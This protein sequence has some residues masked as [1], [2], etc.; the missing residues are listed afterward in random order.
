MVRHPSL[1]ERLGR[2]L[3]PLDA[4]SPLARLRAEEPG[5]RAL[6]AEM[7][8]AAE[9][10]LHVARGVLL[11]TLLAV[12][13]LE[14]RDAPPPFVGIAVGAF[15]VVPVFWLVVWRALTRPRPLRWLPYVLVFV[16][17]WLA[18]RGAVAVKTP[19]YHALRADEY[20]S[21]ADLAAL[22][23]PILA[24]VAMTGGFRLRPRM[25]VY[26][27]GV[28]VLSYAYIAW[29]LGV[30][31]DVALLAGAVIAFLGT[32]SVQVAR[33][34]RHAMLRAR[35]EAVLERYVPAALVRALGLPGPPLHTHC[36]PTRECLC[37]KGFRAPLGSAGR[38]SAR[39]AASGHIALGA[40]AGKRLRQVWSN[41]QG[42]DGNHL[43]GRI[44]PAR[45]A[46][47]RRVSRCAVSPTGSC[48]GQ[49]IRQ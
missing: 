34:F 14:V 19:L 20:L 3:E 6:L 16:D 7:E 45:V 9:R 23:G 32:L 25:A 37:R 49:G 21:P 13:V 35:E 44:S 1:R 46:A 5:S 10:A 48:T 28:A 26:S 29:A 38:C 4:F 12:F 40:Q 22:A 47:H 39:Q 42:V 36:T 11:A 31:R 30:S 2:A 24:L 8:V 17:A 33:V 15:V 18:L 43:S 27:T 41:S